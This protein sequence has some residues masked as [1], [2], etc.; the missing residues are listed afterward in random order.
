MRYVVPEGRLAVGTICRCADILGQTVS[1]AQTQT[2]EFL[3]VRV[4][5]LADIRVA[6]CLGD[7][8]MKT[9]QKTESILQQVRSEKRRIQLRSLLLFPAGTMLFAV[10]FAWMYYCFRLPKNQVGDDREIYQTFLY[11]FYVWIIGLPDTFGV[12]FRPGSLLFALAAVSIAIF[13]TLS[14]S[15]PPPESQDSVIGRANR[16]VLDDF[17]VIVATSCAVL[18]WLTLMTIDRNP[19][20]APDVVAA[21][22]TAWLCSATVPL[23]LVRA[24]V[25]RFT[26]SEAQNHHEMFSTLRAKLDRSE[27]LFARFSR[28]RGFVFYILWIISG[29]TATTVIFVACTLAAGPAISGR[30]ILVYVFAFL[31]IAAWMWFTNEILMQTSLD[32]RQKRHVT[33]V[34]NVVLYL[35]CFFICSFLAYY[36]LYT[37]WNSWLAGVAAV[38]IF[39]APAGAA[40]LDCRSKRLG[41]LTGIKVRRTDTRILRLER[42]IEFAKRQLAVNTAGVS[43]Q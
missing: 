5:T 2:L 15:T 20:G 16:I 25:H 21:V 34:G 36:I 4:R 3:S 22:A 38:V 10:I 32:W 26:L 42:T 29:A 19:Q 23:H 8:T 1:L 28:Q 43:R 40:L 7:K 17:S 9:A 37:L 11:G 6:V 39:L 35:F 12:E 41:M 27:S 18:A 14:T 33:A 24:D 30:T 13:L 31:L